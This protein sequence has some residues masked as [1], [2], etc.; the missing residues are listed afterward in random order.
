MALPTVQ[1]LID[2]ID[3]DL[4]DDSFSTAKKLTVLNDVQREIATD[5]DL[6][7]LALNT[8]VATSL[9][10][11]YVAMPAGFQKKLYKVYSVTEKQDVR[12]LP[13][14]A[15]LHAEYVAS[16]DQSGAVEGVALFGSK[17]H[18]QHIPTG[19]E[20]L[21]LFYYGIPTEMT[22][23]DDT[24]TALPEPLAKDLLLHGAL[25]KLFAKIEDGIEGPK[26]NTRHYGDLFAYDLGR[27][28]HY[29]KTLTRSSWVKPKC[30]L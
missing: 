21:R 17:L 8:T 13:S 16:I 10:L 12:I 14:L 26:M 11:S 24:P 30:W 6:P 5:N 2:E 25:F 23:M 29:L 7:A 4:N 19:A 9:T 15:D 22:E 28:D 3:E 18:Y 27:L 20:T 1:D